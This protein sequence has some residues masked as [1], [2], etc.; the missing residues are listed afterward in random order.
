MS[1]FGKENPSEFRQKLLQSKKTKNAT[2]FAEGMAN[3]FIS[4]RKINCD[5]LD[6]SVDRLNNMF[7]YFYTVQI[8]CTDKD[9]WKLQYS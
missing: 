1:R 6:M 2:T 8:Y 5:L 4:D 9:R 3:E 7:A